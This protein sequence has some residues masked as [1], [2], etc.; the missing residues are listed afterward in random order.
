MGNF[1]IWFSGFLLGALVWTP[2][3]GILLPLCQ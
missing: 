2:I 1:F 3:G